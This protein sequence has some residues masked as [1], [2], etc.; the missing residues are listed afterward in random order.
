MKK[1]DKWVHNCTI[2]LGVV[3]F[4][5][6]ILIAILLI[7]HKILSSL[8]EFFIYDYSMAACVIVIVILPLI[9]VSKC[10]EEGWKK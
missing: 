7:L 1:I 6:L 10:L 2:V 4:I 9:V 8:N 3:S 5:A